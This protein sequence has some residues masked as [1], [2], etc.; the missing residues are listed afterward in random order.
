[1]S[2]PTQVLRDIFKGI[3]NAIRRKDG[4]TEELDK[5]E[6][7][8][9]E[10]RIDA[11][12][13]GTDTS[14]AT[15]SASDI[16]SGKTAYVKGSKITGT[17]P[18]VT[19]LIADTDVTA[20]KSG[21]NL[22]SKGTSSTL[23]MF[24]ASR[25]IEP[26][27][28]IRSY[29][30]L[31]LLGDA[32]TDDVVAGK[33]FTST[34]GIKLTGTGSAGS[35]ADTS[36]ATAVAGDI[37]SGKTA[38]VNGS[39]ITGTI[40]TVS[41]LIADTGVTVT[42][43]GSDLLSSGTSSTLGLFNVSKIVESD[44][45]IRSY[46][47][48]SLLGDATTSDVVAG[49]TFTSTSGIKLTGTAIISS[50]TD[51]SD[52]TAS[53]SDIAL[54]KTAYVNGSK[55]TG[56]LNE[57]K[58]GSFLNFPSKWTSANIELS[59]SGSSS[60]VVITTNDDGFSTERIF[61]M[62]SKVKFTIPSSLFGDV[63]PEDIASEK[64][65]TSSSGIKISGSATSTSNGASVSLTANPE[66][67]GSYFQ[68]PYSFPINRHFYSGSTL[69][70]RC[71]ASKLGNATAS[72][73]ASGK[74]FTSSHGVL[75]TGTG[76]SGAITGSVTPTSTTYIDVTVSS[77]STKTKL[78]LY[79]MLDST[80]SGTMPTFATSTQNV[81]T[82]I[83][84]DIQNNRIHFTTPGPFGAD[85]SKIALYHDVYTFTPT[86]TAS[87]SNIVN[88]SSTRVRIYRPSINWLFKDMRY[89]YVLI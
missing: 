33:T 12:Q 87:S 28:N 44:V 78:I 25:I 16:A 56:T 89:E 40:T 24:N 86:T 47:P 57:I 61:R 10:T 38:Y 3:A 54:N 13:T 71:L 51:T 49:R 83:M 77:A 65:A 70:L 19:T 14:D 85:G 7:S 37:R 73:V 11:I 2:T 59:G 81:M 66:I 88:I 26:T 80:S 72:D 35:G 62:G 5:I 21:D 82:I 36:D 68:L 63:A 48:L 18:T 41:T 79:A 53:A 17:I 75:L 6:P 29:I 46:I 64:T 1:M 39:K 76:G 34:S 9:F 84:V 8:D 55:I 27:V 30:P 45:T 23:A 43:S 69:N 52:A 60:N 31:D 32:T 22:L 4:T 74:T 58:S 42:K 15:A 67:S 20:I 50:G